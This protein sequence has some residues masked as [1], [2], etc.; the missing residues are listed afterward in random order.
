MSVIN[1][2]HLAM[3]LAMAILVGGCS[4]SNSANETTKNTSSL[5]SEIKD[6]PNDVSEWVLKDADIV[7]TSTKTD[8]KGN[9][10]LEQG[11]F[12]NH[13]GLLNKR[14][15]FD[16]EIELDSVSSDIVIRDQ[17]LKE[18]LFEV[19]KFATAHI[20]GQL[21]A[22]Q[23]SKLSQNETLQL[24]QPIIIA[25]HD[26]EV[27]TNADLLINRV[28]DRQIKVETVKP[29]Y[30]NVKDLGMGEGLQ[31]LTDVMKLAKINADVP[32]IFKGEF[33]RP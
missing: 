11:T 33:V 21:D 6:V 28:D 30:L 24:H 18:W 10:I 9:D 13:S 5:S 25:L 4:P 14:G 32:I 12:K 3:M 2:L 31:Q 26:N 8:Q 27:K 22:A 17:R 20:T 15:E 16:I 7:F 29:I 19:D 1:K 23:I